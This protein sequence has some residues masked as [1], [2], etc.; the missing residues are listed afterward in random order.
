MKEELLFR[1]TLSGA[2]TAA[3]VTALVDSFF[4]VNELSW[5][6]FK[7]ICTDGAPAIIST[8]SG[9]VTLMKNEWPHVTSSHCS[10]PR[11]TLVSKTLPLHLTEVMDVAV[12][13]INLIP[14]RGKDRRLFQLLTQEMGLLFYIKVRCLSRLYKLENE[15]E[16]FLRE[17][18]T[19][20]ISNLTIKSL[21]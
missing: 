2:T 18:K 12:K 5:K 8:K 17:N 3:N 4:D 10:L 9:F 6:N 11:C 20:S 14:S 21:L 1:N 19:T 7:H 13:V 16:I 15:V